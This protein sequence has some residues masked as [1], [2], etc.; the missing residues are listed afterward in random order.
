MDCG[1]K[2]SILVWTLKKPNITEEIV[3]WLRSWFY[4]LVLFHTALNQGAEQ[5]DVSFSFFLTQNSQDSWKCEPMKESNPWPCFL[6]NASLLVLVGGAVGKVKARHSEWRHCLRKAFWCSSLRV[7]M[8]CC[9]ATAA[10]GA[11]EHTP[12]QILC[13]GPPHM[14]QFRMCL[15]VA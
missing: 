3:P 14:I 5:K 10:S 11:A 12:W 8:D 13:L 2:S 15:Y 7:L 6:P 9:T 1:D 4:T